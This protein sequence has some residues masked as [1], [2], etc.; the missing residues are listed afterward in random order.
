VVFLRPRRTLGQYPPICCDCIVAFHFTIFNHRSVSLSAVNR[1]L[2]NSVQLYP[3]SKLF[4]LYNLLYLTEYN[5][6][7]LTLPR[8]NCV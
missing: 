4:E 6:L 5:I 3:H 7:G 1:T 8:I 2:L